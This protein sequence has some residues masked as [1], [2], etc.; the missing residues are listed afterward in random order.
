MTARHLFLHPWQSCS[1]FDRFRCIQ[2]TMGVMA[3][4]RS[5]HPINGAFE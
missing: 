4:G 5:I 2:S 3:K 1:V